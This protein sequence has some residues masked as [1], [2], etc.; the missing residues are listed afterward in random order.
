MFVLVTSYLWCRYQADLSK[1]VTHL[2]AS[3]SALTKPTQKL[4]VAI[5]Q[6]TTNQ[7][8]INVVESS[9][10]KAC[11][12]QKGLVPCKPYMICA[13]L[14]G[15]RKQNGTTPDVVQRRAL[16]PRVNGTLAPAVAQH[17]NPSGSAALP[18]CQTT[19]LTSPIQR[20]QAANP[21][22][23]TANS[24]PLH[25]AVADAAGYIVA[26]DTQAADDMLMP[27]HVPILPTRAPPSIARGGSPPSP[28]HCESEPQMSEGRS[29][30]N[31]VQSHDVLQQLD[32]QP[33]A[34]TCSAAVGETQ[35]M[36]AGLAAPCSSA[37]GMPAD[38]CP[39]RGKQSPRH[40]LHDVQ[41]LHS[42]AAHSFRLYVLCACCCAQSSP[43]FHS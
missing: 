26:P 32:A 40:A 12:K 37:I 35:I 17:A 25:Q 19:G 5:G 42:S 20:Q 27:T 39:V 3:S 24:P 16:A 6:R 11:H 38:P 36:S 34:A 10:L 31:H 15:R 8:R 21:P 18:H 29:L 43:E 30:G 7:W 13:P 22:P 9:W 23:A 2:V 28:A 41:V 14:A 1:A 4:L 33:A